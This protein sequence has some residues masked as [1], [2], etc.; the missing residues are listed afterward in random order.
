MSLRADVLKLINEDYKENTYT[1][2][3]SREIL[4]EQKKLLRNTRR[5]KMLLTR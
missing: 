4:F 2:M 1:G 3:F 5:P